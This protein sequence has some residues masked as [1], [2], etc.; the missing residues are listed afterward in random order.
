MKHTLE[1]DLQVCFSAKKSLSLA[2]FGETALGLLKGRRGLHL[3]EAADA[4]EEQHK[5][6]G[7]CAVGWMRT[8]K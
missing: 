7:T 8:E 5:P 4:C 3:E 1:A 6:Q 2:G